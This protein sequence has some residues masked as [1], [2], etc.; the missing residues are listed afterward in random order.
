V[1][2][3]VYRHDTERS[4]TVT[5]ARLPVA[6][7]LRAVHTLTCMAQVAAQ[8]LTD[9]Q[10][11]QRLKRDGP[12]VL[13]TAGRRPIARIALQVALQPMF[14]LLLSTAAVYAL[15][16]SAGDAAVLLVSVVAVGSLSLMQ[17]YRAE[18][19]LEALKELA[20]P[21]ARV[22]RSGH[23]QRIASR[24]L[25]VGDRLLVGE[26]DRIACDAQIVE[27]NG[28]LVDESMLTGESV[29]VLKSPAGTSDG[30]AHLLRAGTLVV[31]GD[32]VALVSAT[33][34]RTALGQIGGT[35]SQLAPPP[36]RL[37]REL[38]RVVRR[39]AVFAVLASIGAALLFTARHGSLVNG[40]LAGLT[41][42]MA[43]IPEEFA[44]V[45]T[46][47]LA[48]G[49]WRLARHRVL[50]RQSQAIETLGTTT[51]LA[52]DK[53]GTLTNNRMELMALATPL[54]T[55]TLAVGGIADARFARLL[56][57]AVLASAHDGIE[58]MDNALIR[59]HERSFGAAAFDGKLLERQGVAP[60]R[61]YFTNRWQRT[62][63]SGGVLAVKGAP[64]AV[65][66]L[67]DVE[68]DLAQR[69]KDDAERLG[70]QG[71]R[72]LGVACR[73]WLGPC[74]PRVGAPLEWI[75]LLAFLDPLRDDAPAAI[76]QCRAAGMRVVM[77]T[78]DAPATALAIAR[79]A[80]LAQT[81]RQALVTG[82]AL[83]RLTQAQLERAVATTTVYAR[84]SPHQK[85]RIV[86]ALQARGEV[87]A[88][89]GDGVND[90]SA[91]RAADIGVAMGQRGTDVAREAAALVLLDDRFA[92][93]VKAVRTG[94][95]IFGNLRNAVGY[96]IAVHVPIV[97][98][99]LLPVLTGGPTLLLP[100]HVVL[101][102]LIIDPACS[103]VFEAEPEPADCMA[104]PPRPRGVGLLS[105]HA[106]ERA[107]AIGAL[108][109]LVV[110][111]LIVAG[112]LLGL[113][114]PALRVAALGGLIASN[115]VMLRWYLRG[116]ARGH[117]ARNRA[118]GWL[119]AGVGAACAALLV[120]AP[121]FPQLGFPHDARLGLAAAFFAAAALW[122]VHRAR[123]GR[124]RADSAIHTGVRS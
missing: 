48:L 112:S 104:K 98:V 42:A 100:L 73:E 24:D 69:I 63:R 17:E 106:I 56:H 116:A 31:Q 57:L 124:A 81:T 30:S 59:L 105:S 84:V 25:V 80:G 54:E 68:V 86:Q 41:L 7:R 50:T 43:I 61:P 67:C 72:V 13:V 60:E 79:A 111:A 23:L 5:A 75:G 47:M 101:L 19:A 12:N 18:R 26:G 46:V 77:I 64:E 93:L 107:L 94:R 89:T 113:E 99:S 66:S 108:A 92:S 29:P 9:Q 121:W 102:E 8:G 70:Q 109:T 96:L 65:L 85:L 20:S 2:V 95:R 74:S 53:T 120:A 114:A 35:L 115:L 76:A 78:G 91:L 97:G 37:Q 88:M 21:R 36:S 110:V 87:V 83:E 38:Q 52:V 6:E 45:W 28:L 119:L 123:R 1:P 33:G 14:L 118:F 82:A 4:P 44:V 55:A 15:L 58:P 40:L 62:D 51:V 3:A 11:A 27:A 90:A 16:G 117:G 49:A 34:A 32:G 22:L 103:L 122:A 39:V 10:A 71:L